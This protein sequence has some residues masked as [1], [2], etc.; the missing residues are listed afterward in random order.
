MRKAFT[1]AEVLITLGIIGVVASMTLPALIN[2]T[3]GAQYKTALQKSYSIITQALQALNADQG[4]VATRDT[5]ANR[6]FANY[7]K[8][9]F[10]ILKDCNLE[11][12]VGG[13]TDENG[14]FIINTYKTFSK[15]RKV[16]SKFF[17]DGQFILTDGMV[18]LIEDNTDSSGTGSGVGSMFI[19]VDINGYNKNP[20]AWGHDLFTFQIMNDSGKLLPMGAEGTVFEDLDT[21]C[22]PTSSNAQ[23]GIACTYRALTEKDY[24]NNLP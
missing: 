2:K 19:S 22:S 24:F 16:S 5:Y 6:T 23:N 7:Y 3:H 8:K 10:K 20:N 21:Y 17:D 11:S 9:Y 18:L 12:C 14:T 4:F 15:N 1:L 13:A